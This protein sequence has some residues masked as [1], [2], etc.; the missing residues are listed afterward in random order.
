MT[1]K[2]LKALAQK[3]ATNPII[4][5]VISFLEDKFPEGVEKTVAKKVK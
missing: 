4:M 3:E 1:I 5:E 2:E